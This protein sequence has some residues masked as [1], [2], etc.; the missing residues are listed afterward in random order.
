VVPHPIPEFVT[1]VWWRKDYPF[2]KACRFYQWSTQFSKYDIRFHNVEI[3]HM[4]SACK[5][6]HLRMKQEKRR[7][8]AR[9]GDGGNARFACTG[10]SINMTMK[11]PKR[12]A[13]PDV[14]LIISFLSSTRAPAMPAQLIDG[15][16]LSQ[17]L[18]ADIARPRRRRSPPP[19]TS[20]AWP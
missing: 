17:Q 2:D 16:K 5:P 6:S 20:P 8:R 15:V 10:T 19:A 12:R 4:R 14:A 13:I 18:R 1:D 7:P 11:T 9:G 3:R